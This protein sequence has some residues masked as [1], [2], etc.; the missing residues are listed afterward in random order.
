MPLWKWSQLPMS[1]VL[2]SITYTS[3]C[4]S[5]PFAGVM[6]FR[7]QPQTYLEISSSLL[8]SWF[9][10]KTKSSCHDLMHLL[11]S[12]PHFCEWNDQKLLQG[13]TQNPVARN[14]A[15]V[16]SQW[17]RELR[18]FWCRS[19][20]F[21]PTHLKHDNK[22]SEVPSDKNFSGCLTNLPLRFKDLWGGK[23]KKNPTVSTQ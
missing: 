20:A 10:K 15:T 2:A 16:T 1:N 14:W 22:L 12:K 17:R 5:V 9:Y 7:T 18:L 8:Q 6:G 13:A 19:S 11:S 4:Y 3:V 23:K 21:R